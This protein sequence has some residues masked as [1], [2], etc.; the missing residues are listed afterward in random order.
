[1]GYRTRRCSKY[2]IILQKSP[3]RV[4]GC[5]NSHWIRDAWNE[6]VDR[7]HPHAKPIGLTE[8]LIRSV[9]SPGDLVL[10]PCTGS[11]ST[12]EACDASGRNFIGCDL[13]E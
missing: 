9:T 6:P 2:L 7:V 12:L 3:K 11:Y 13:A 5:W 10:D 1:M 8:A 4:K